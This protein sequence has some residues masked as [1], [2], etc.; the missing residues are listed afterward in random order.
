MKNKK[1]YNTPKYRENKQVIVYLP[2]KL[3]RIVVE[4]AKDNER[5]ISAEV[6]FQLNLSYKSGR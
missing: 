1:I 4:S 5:S 2:P 6:C 3:K